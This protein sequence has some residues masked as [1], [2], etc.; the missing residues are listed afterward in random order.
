MG[1]DGVEGHQ[2]LAWRPPSGGGVCLCVHGQRVAAVGLATV[3]SL[4][5]QARVGDTSVNKR[6]VPDLGHD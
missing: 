5:S 2:V 3:S 4:G 1:V 6:L